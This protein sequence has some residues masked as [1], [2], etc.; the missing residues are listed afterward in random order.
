MR[1]N[2]FGDVEKKNPPKKISRSDILQQVK[3]IDVT[4]GK[5]AELNDRREINRE[6]SRVKSST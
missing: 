1:L 3:D 4:F 5:P 2:F 6:R